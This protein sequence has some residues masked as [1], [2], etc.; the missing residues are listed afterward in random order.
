MINLIKTNYPDFLNSWGIKE[1]IDVPILQVNTT[2]IPSQRCFQN[3]AYHQMK[4][5]GES[6]IGFNFF[7][8]YHTIMVEPHA[9]WKNEDD[10]LIDICLGSE[11]PAS[12]KHITFA[13]LVSYDAS[14]EYYDVF[15]RYLFEGDDI[16]RKMGNSAYERHAIDFFK[17][18]DFS[19]LIFHRDYSITKS[20]SWEDYLEERLD[21]LEGVE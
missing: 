7:K 2:K 9:V 1:I 10:E 6:V 3:V 21:L 5:G 14:K 16:L 13:P 17:D 18:K 11:R 8:N 4:N 12:T 20:D 15:D 19:Q